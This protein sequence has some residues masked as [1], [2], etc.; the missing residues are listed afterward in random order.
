VTKRHPHH[1]KGRAITELEK[2]PTINLSLEV[3]GEFYTPT[4]TAA[5]PRMLLRDEDGKLKQFASSLVLLARD[6]WQSEKNFWLKLKVGEHKLRCFFE[7]EGVRGVSHL[8]LF[9][10]KPAGPF[11]LKIEDTWEI[12]P[13]TCQQET[14][15]VG[16]SSGRILRRS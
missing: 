2:A 13:L 15:N 7:V 3:D 4:K 1:L 14:S 9:T 8:V 11:K 10:I 12:P 16:K 5:P 6:D